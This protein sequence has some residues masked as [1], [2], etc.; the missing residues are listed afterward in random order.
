MTLNQKSKAKPILVGSFINSTGVQAYDILT[1][2]WPSTG[3]SL[4][5]RQPRHLPWLIFETK[6]KKV[7][8]MLVSYSVIWPRNHFLRLLLLKKTFLMYLV[9]LVTLNSNFSSNDLIRKKNLF[10]WFFFFF[11]PTN[12]HAIPGGCSNKSLGSPNRQKISFN[13]WKYWN[14]KAPIT[15]QSKYPVLH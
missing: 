5:P 14:S 7:L 8:N 10:F 15:P 9:V 12:S 6:V 13:K 3:A 11:V 2:F 1:K 4:P